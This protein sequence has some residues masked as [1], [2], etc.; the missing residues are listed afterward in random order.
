MNTLSFRSYVALLVLS[1]I[2]GCS[3]AGSVEEQ[4]VEVDVAAQALSRAPEVPD[5]IKV[6]EGNR[7][8]FL[9]DATGFQV[10]ECRTSA[11]APSGYA[12]TLLAPDADLWKPNGRFAG[13]HYAGPTWEYLDGSAVIGARVSGYTDDPASI[14]WLLLNATSHT[15][16]GR[17]SKVSFIQ[18]LYTSGGLAPATG[19]DADHLG[20]QTS[21][22]YTTTYYFYEPKS[23]CSH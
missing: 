6:P 11:T 4:G 1:W 8:A 13:T 10:Y 23:A 18:R 9:L 21:I 19:C 16:K 5:V 20:A 7:L 3:A 12:W 14:P 22:D 17:M 15:G 2:G